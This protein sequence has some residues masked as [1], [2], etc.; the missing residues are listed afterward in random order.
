VLTPGILQD[1]Q[2]AITKSP[3]KSSQKLSVQTGISLGSAHTAVSQNYR[4]WR[5]EN[6]HN[7]T[8]TPLHPQKIGV[9]CAI[10]RR[11]TIGPLFFDTS[12]NA[13]GYQEL[14][15]QFIVLLQVD[16]R[17]CCFQQDI[18]TAHTAASIMVFCMNFSV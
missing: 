15:Q 2:T 6:P 5:T 7:Y 14:I 3:H 11:Q 9:W 16:E 10:S 1:I 18:P 8:E 13:A 12:I 4:T 17:N